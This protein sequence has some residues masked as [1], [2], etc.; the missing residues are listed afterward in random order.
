MSFERSNGPFKNLMSERKFNTTDPFHV[1]RVVS[2]P[3]PST[4]SGLSPEHAHQPWLAPGTPG[5]DDVVPP[6]IDPET[7]VAQWAA[8]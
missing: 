1:T 4:R 7:Q 6:I 5:H 3:R 2:A 8:A